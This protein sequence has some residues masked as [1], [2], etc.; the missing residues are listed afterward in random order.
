MELQVVLI[1]HDSLEPQTLAALIDEFVTRDGAV[2]GHRDASV[3]QMRESVLQQLRSG[4]V[5]ILYDEDE[6]SCTIAAKE[7]LS[8]NQ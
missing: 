6:E 1:P 3:E 8:G 5:V 4:K 2:H 7:S